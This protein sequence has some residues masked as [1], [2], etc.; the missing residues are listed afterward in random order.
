V[1]LAAISVDLDE[2]DCYAAIHGLGQE[3]LSDAARH[4]VYDRALPRLTAMFERLAVPVTWFAIGRDLARAQNAA[5]L[6]ALHRSGHEVA[7]HSLN[8]YYDLTRRP[9]AQQASEVRGGADAIEQAVGDRP[10][11]F[12]APGYTVTNELMSV[13]QAQGVSYDASV[14]PCP[15]YYSAKAAAMAAIRLRGRKSKSVLDHPRVLL[16]PAEPYRV[17]AD[18]TKRGSGIVEIPNGV[19]SDW[20][21]RLPFIGTSLTLAGKRGAAFLSHLVAARDFVSLEL[22]GIDLADAEEDGLS[23]LVAHQP[24]L[25]KSARAKEA[26]LCEA[27]DVLR[28]RGCSFVTLAQAAKRF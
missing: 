4:A 8:H 14:F 20:S 3:Q 17:G 10:V 22:H 9:R 11:G 26:A 21:G 16:A 24:D 13:L 19:T 5:Q 27:I 12:R 7:N 25:T 6:K 1:K 18:Y 23:A 28:R 15:T 2:I